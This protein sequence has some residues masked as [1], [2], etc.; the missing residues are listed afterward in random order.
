[1]NFSLFQLKI[2]LDI[3][4]LPLL[5]FNCIKNSNGVFMIS[6]TA[7]LSSSDIS[8]LTHQKNSLTTKVYEE[9]LDRFMDRK[10]IPGQIINRRELAKELGVSVAPVLEALVQLEMDGFFESVPRKG[11]IVSPVKEEDAYAQL[12]IRE[13]LETT[14]VRIYCGKPVRTLYE[15]FKEFAQWMDEMSSAGKELS[16]EHTKAEIRFHAS[17]VNLCNMPMFTREFIRSVRIGVFS[18]I[19]RIQG[20]YSERQSHVELLDKLTTDNKEDAIEAIKYH[21]W[22]GKPIRKLQDFF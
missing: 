5:V 12:L 15:E 4:Q 13:S 9:L 7:I 3:S 19:N 14:A 1:M 17:L 6:S 2:I 16:L 18:N 20:G 10:L 11:T 8:K 22:S 21:L